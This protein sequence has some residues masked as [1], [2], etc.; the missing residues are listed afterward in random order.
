MEYD[1]F[2]STR[3]KENSSF[4][5]NY[6]TVHDT[7]SEF[8]EKGFV[9]SFWALWPDRLDTE[10]EGNKIRRERH[11]MPMIQVTKSEFIIFNPLMI[12]STVF[13]QSGQNL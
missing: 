2:I 8:G 12:G 1:E 9:Q 3:D 6:C 11:A 4:C 13:A 10:V 5:I 7:A